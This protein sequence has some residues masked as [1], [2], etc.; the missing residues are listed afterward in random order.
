M[1]TIYFAIFCV[2]IFVAILWG[3]IK[4]DHDEFHGGAADKRFSL[5]KKTPPNNTNIPD[6]G[7]ND[8]NIM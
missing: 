2:I 5:K 8:A 6:S 7:K 3:L 4:D 1:N